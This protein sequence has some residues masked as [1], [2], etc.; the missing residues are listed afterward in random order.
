M[1]IDLTDAQLDCVRRI[2]RLHLPEEEI[3][4]FGSRAGQTQKR[5]ADL[6]LAILSESPLSARRLALL[7]E[8]LAESDLPFRV[9]LVDWSTVSESMRQRIDAAHEILLPRA[10]AGSNRQHD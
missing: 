8:D 1:P 6:D 5:Y 4:V 9:D 2:V 10:T 3:W 7:A